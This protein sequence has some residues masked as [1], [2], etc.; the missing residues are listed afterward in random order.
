M[1]T[2]TRVSN[3]TEQKI[4]ALGRL[5]AECDIWVADPSTTEADRRVLRDRAES[6][7]AMQIMLL[8]QDEFDRQEQEAALQGLAERI[9]TMKEWPGELAAEKAVEA[10]RLRRKNNRETRMVIGVGVLG[11]GLAVYW[12]LVRV[13]ALATLGGVL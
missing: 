12:F 10:E 8:E 6:Y 7:R 11:L 3:E 9:G 2:L 5:A 4:R 13:W 1:I